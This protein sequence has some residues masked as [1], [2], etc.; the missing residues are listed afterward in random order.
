METAWKA[1]AERLVCRW[2][3]G[4]E[5]VRYDSPWI[6]DALKTVDRDNVPRAILDLSKVSPFGREWYAAERML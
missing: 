4:A 6:H 3:N 2:A 1:T 5:R